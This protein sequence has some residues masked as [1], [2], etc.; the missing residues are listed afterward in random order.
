MSS[1]YNIGTITIPCG[2]AD[3]EAV[4]MA[5]NLVLAAGVKAV[6]GRLDR[7]EGGQLFLPFAVKGDISLGQVRRAFPGCAVAAKPLPLSLGDKRALGVAGKLEGVDP[8]KDVIAL[9]QVEPIADCAP[10]DQGLVGMRD[11]LETLHS[12]VKAVGE[13]GRDALESLHMVFV[14]PPG[15][16]KTMIAQRLLGLFDVEGITS[17]KGVFVAASA[18][19]LVSPYV[20]ETSHFV[21]RVFDRARGGLL[22]IDEAYRLSR[23]SSA[24]DGTSHGQ[25]AIDA[26]NQLMEERRENTVVV[27]AGYPDE[28]REFL[29]RNPGLSGRI[30]FELEFPG[31][32]DAELLDI[33]HGMA[34]ARGFEVDAAAACLLAARLPRL[35]EQEGFANART[36]RK[37]VD[38]AIV[39]KS[40]GALNRML[41]AA[42]LEHALAGKEFAGA[43]KMPV[44]FAC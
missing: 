21:K 13:Y 4:T 25:E 16:G 9:S 43:A 37:L 18:T 5:C 44:G 30:G 40:L 29:Q 14:G 3:A 31:Y 32:T 20:G 42:D 26:I 6:F 23:Q 2:S 27:L 22:F 7:G 33:F 28:M 17:G 39:K 35:K 36:M 38:R 10:L 1:E 8:K 24:V 34:H 19:E 11:Q 15:V 41:G 12:I